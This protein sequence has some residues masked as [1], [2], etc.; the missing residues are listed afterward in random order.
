MNQG[1]QFRVPWQTLRWV[2]ALGLTVLLNHVGVIE[3][4]LQHMH[5]TAPA[6]VLLLA[7]VLA[8]R[9]LKFVA[10][11]VKGNRQRLRGIPGALR[12]FVLRRRGGFWE[13]TA[14]ALSVGGIALPLGYAAYLV[15][16]DAVTLVQVPLPTLAGAGLSYLVSTVSRPLAVFVGPLVAIG[17]ASA[18]DTAHRPAVEFVGGAFSSVVGLGLMHLGDFQNIGART[19]PLGDDVTFDAVLLSGFVACWLG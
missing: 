10:F 19:F 2:C 12:Q 4:D 6:A 9:H 3:V 14:I 16:C 7:A 1:W 13:S 15:L 11:S 17:F 18:V 8:S 5:L